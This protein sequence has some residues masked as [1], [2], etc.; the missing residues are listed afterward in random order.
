MHPQL[1]FA[2]TSTIDPGKGN[3]TTRMDEPLLRMKESLQDA[4]DDLSSPRSSSES[5]SKAL[6]TI[7]RHL[8]QACL[9]KESPENLDNFTALQYTFECNV[10]SRLL[11][12]IAQSTSTLETLTNKGAMDHE[13]EAQ[14]S[15]LSSQLSLSLSLIQGVVLNHPASKTYLGRKYALEATRPSTATP[16]PLS[17]MVLDTLLCILVDSPTALRAFEDASGIQ[18]IV[19]ILKR[20]GTPREVRMKCLEFLY[21]Y[22][23]DETSAT[24]GLGPDVVPTP[25]PTAPAT[26]IR[27]T[28]PYFSS[29]PLR[30]SSRYGS[31]EFSFPAGSSLS[32][33]SRS[34]SGSSANS[35]SS[36][37]SIAS[38][39][40][41]PTSTS[42]S[43]SKP[44]SMPQPKT[45]PNSKVPQQLQP[46]SLLMLR[47]EVDYV[48]Q[49][50]K[51]PQVSRSAVGGPS[52]HTPAKS[53]SRSRL[54]SQSEDDCRKFRQVTPAT[55]PAEQEP[56]AGINESEDWRIGKVRTTEEKKELLGTMLGNVDALV[57][58]V[59]KA[60]IW[61]LG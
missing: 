6:Q 52:R 28:K 10:P 48:P 35:F 30:P 44:S 31:S 40:T 4:L 20:A 19:K 53:I 32:G 23:L 22:L 39:S 36:T 29:K 13:R 43:P 27:P 25:P 1:S 9:S 8:A 54:G 41:A 58:G 57:E 50:P 37:S 21:F 42:S 11:A 60:G 45:P 14:A 56:R 55:P 47:K 46:R 49:S 2:T 51:K 3:T 38:V 59:R 16:P 34:T 18:A 15:K 5:K 24:D 7:E 26:P 17:S 33:T 61:G 12:W